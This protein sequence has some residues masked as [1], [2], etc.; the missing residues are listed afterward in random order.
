MAH[1]YLTVS[2]YI[3]P[4][5]TA[6][7]RTFR[8]LGWGAIILLLGICIVSIYEPMELR[9]SVRRVLAWTAGAIVLSVVVLAMVLSSRGGLRKLKEGYQFELSDGKITQRREGQQTVEIPLAQIESLHEYRS[10]LVIRGA[11]PARQITIPLEVNGF[12]ELKRE[13]TAYR[14]V[15]PLQAKIRLFSFFPL[16]LL[17]VA[18]LYL[19]T[20]HNSAIVLAAGGAVLLLQGLGFYSIWRLR[21]NVSR[22]KLLLLLEV[23]I[24]LATAWIVYERA[25]GA[26]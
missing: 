20:S 6:N 23:L 12:E 18:C 1:T 5:D 19:F 8:I 13:L 15:T 26:M 14:A 24:W 10:W 11:Q 16:V 25:K 17:I 9:D 7:W 4:G 21:R 2:L 3:V 22:P